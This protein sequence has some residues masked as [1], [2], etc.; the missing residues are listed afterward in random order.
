MDPLHTPEDNIS[1]TTTTAHTA[2]TCSA[3]PFVVPFYKKHLT[4]IA[5]MVAAILIIGGAGGYVYLTKYGNGD[6]VAVINGKKIYEKELSE[7][8]AL[9]EENVAGQGIDPREA[10]VQ[11]EI[12]KQAIEILLNNA[13]LLT[14]A[15]DVGIEVTPEDIDTKYQELVKQVGTVEELSKRMEEIGL[16]EKKL[17][18]NISDRILADRY[19]ESVTDIETLT[20]TEE[21]VQEFI[22]A[23]GE[24][25]SELPPLEEIRPQIEAQILSQKQQQLVSDLIAKLK[26]EATIDIRI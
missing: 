5:S 8:I 21:E 25:G 4:I 20:V 18:E 11:T 7:S 10:S 16:T 26:T 6:V 2:P 24:G 3:E 12:K 14:A 23:L 9:I 1:S 17:R 13:L 22:K 19:I 15:S